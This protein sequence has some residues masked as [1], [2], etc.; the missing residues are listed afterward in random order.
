VGRIVGVQLAIQFIEELGRS[1]MARMISCLGL[2]FLLLG[3]GA[4]QA[5][6]QVY[7][8][9]TNGDGFVYEDDVDAVVDHLNTYGYPCY[10]DED[11]SFYVDVN[12]TATLQ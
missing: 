2:G 10:P 8:Y 6:A 11:Y 12:L 9:D 5:I 1:M 3:I 4:N 7:L